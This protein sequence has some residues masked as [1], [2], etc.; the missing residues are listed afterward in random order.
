[1]AAKN[2]A[3]P[4]RKSG[5]GQAKANQTLADGNL[6]RSLAKEIADARGANSDT[7]KSLSDLLSE[8]KKK[9]IDPAMLRLAER[10]VRTAEKKPVAGAVQW[11]NLQ[12]YL[13]CLG[14]HTKIAAMMFKHDEKTQQ[15]AA[16]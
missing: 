3:R 9:G 11:E 6:V 16:H 4:K 2:G 13:E 1:M 7:N 15:A 10:F 8:N 5:N 12:H 14:F